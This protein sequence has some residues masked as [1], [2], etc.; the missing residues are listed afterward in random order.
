ML[1]GLA[2]LTVQAL[3]IAGLVY[4]RRAWQRAEIDSRR[5]LAL[6]ADVNRRQTTAALTGSIT[7]EIGQPLSSMMPQRPS[8][9]D[10]G[11]RRSGDARGDAG[12]PVRY[13]EPG[14]ARDADHRAPRTMLRGHQVDLKPV[15][16]H[17]V[18]GESLALV[19]HDMRARQI[20]A[21]LKLPSSALRHQRRSGP[22]GAGAREPDGQ[23][24]GR[25]GRDAAGPA[26]ASRSGARPG[27]PM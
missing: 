11:R 20:E 12:E 5:N 17:A 2:A 9:S 26:P 6:A 27:P 16:P 22:V 18:I 7:H 1:S 24:D 13:P 10:D 25:D 4:Q 21:T 14:R 19:A 3:L 23:R 8:P 15:E